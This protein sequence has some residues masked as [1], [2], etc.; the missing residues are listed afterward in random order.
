MGCTIHIVDS[1]YLLFTCYVQVF[2][3]KVNPKTFLF[4]IIIG[5]ELGTYVDAQSRKSTIDVMCSLY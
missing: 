1:V 5:S 3:R 4:V 2:T